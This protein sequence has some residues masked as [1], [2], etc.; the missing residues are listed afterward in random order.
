MKIYIVTIIHELSIFHLLMSTKRTFKML[1]LFHI[2]SINMV[3]MIKYK[4]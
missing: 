3:Q 2:K 4:G 1:L